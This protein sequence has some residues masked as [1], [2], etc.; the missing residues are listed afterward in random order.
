MS[1]E[2]IKQPDVNPINLYTF[3]GNLR[4]WFAG[5]A[6]QGIMSDPSPAPPSDT[7]AAWAYRQADA[8]LERRKK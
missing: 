4:D 3:P 7:V 5:M 6:L 2:T 8:M 1:D